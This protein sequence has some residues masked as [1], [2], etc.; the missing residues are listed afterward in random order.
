MSILKKLGPDSISRLVN[1][2]SSRHEEASYLFEGGRYLASIYLA[3]YAAEMT[4]GAAYFR[5]VREYG[6]NRRIEPNDFQKILKAARVL[7]TLEDKSHPIDGLA[8][9]LIEEKRA[10]NPPAIDD[11]IEQSLRKRVEI[12]ARDWGPKLRYRAIQATSEEA[13]RVLRAVRWII[14]H[15]PK[16]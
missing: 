7:S 16:H 1:A 8:E 11:K 5:I 12:V 14:D 13:D 10:L 15:C 9:L 2:A 4:I 3:G 6:S